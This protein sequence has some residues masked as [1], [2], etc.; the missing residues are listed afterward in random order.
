MCFALYSTLLRLLFKPIELAWKMVGHLFWIYFL[1]GIKKCYGFLY[2]F[3]YTYFMQLIY[4]S[5]SLPSHNSVLSPEFISTEMLVN[6][7]GFFI[8]HLLFPTLFLLRPCTEGSTVASR[9]PSSS[10]TS[11]SACPAASG[12]LCCFPLL[13]VYAKGDRQPYSLVCVLNCGLPLWY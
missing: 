9:I 6:A 13:D 8:L 3:L 7:K 5:Q 1:L 12:A 2:Y 11:N 4:L 10:P